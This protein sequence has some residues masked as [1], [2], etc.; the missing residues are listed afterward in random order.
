MINSAV[1]IDHKKFYKQINSLLLWV[2]FIMIAG[3]FTWSEN[4]AV[5]RVIKVISRIGMTVASYLIYKKIVNYGAVVS[6]GWRN[7]LSPLLYV[8]YLLLGLISFLWST[9][10][11]YS[12]LQWIMDIEGFVFAFFLLEASVC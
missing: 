12:A 4:V 11:G 1:H 8:C 10:I 6:F 7:I 3:F 5:T 9:N 2:L